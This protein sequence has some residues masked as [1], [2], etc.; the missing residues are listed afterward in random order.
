MLPS[1]HVSKIHFELE[2]DDDVASVRDLKSTRGTLVNE[3][4][5]ILSRELEVGDRIR[6]GDLVFELRHGV[7][8]WDWKSAHAY[9]GAV[10]HDGPDGV[11]VHPVFR[12]VSE[13]D[14]HAPGRVVR[15]KVTASSSGIRIDGEGRA[16]LLIERSSEDL[17]LGGCRVDVVVSRRWLDDVPGLAIDGLGPRD[18][19]DPRDEAL[20]ASAA[21]ARQTLPLP[22]LLDYLVFPVVREGHQLLVATAHVARPGLR[23]DLTSLT[24]WNIAF[25]R[26]GVEE[27]L[28]GIVRFRAEFQ[29][30]GELLR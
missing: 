20:A 6:A 17:D 22:T 4:R 13:V 3:E 28:E 19:F 8:R 7:A 16:P 25:R 10:L 24:G 12:G 30:R 26:A 21:K 27:I 9:A 15:C 11:T 29:R 14:L 23:D 5:L 18:V 2:I 1:S